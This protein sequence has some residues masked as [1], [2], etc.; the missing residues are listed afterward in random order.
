[1]QFND[2][3]KKYRKEAFSERDKGDKF[4]RLMQRYLRTDPKYAHSFKKVWLLNQSGAPDWMLR[5][6]R[7]QCLR[8]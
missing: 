5:P 1:M 2:I 4:E 6:V 3:L 7:R 8:R